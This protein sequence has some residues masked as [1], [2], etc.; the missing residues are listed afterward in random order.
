M[1]DDWKSGLM[2]QWTTQEDN[3]TEIEWTN[4]GGSTWNPLDV[5]FEHSG[6]A[7]QSG[8]DP[9]SGRSSWSDEYTWDAAGLTAGTYRLRLTPV[10]GRGNV[11]A[12]LE[13]LAFVVVPGPALP[14][15]YNTDGVVDAADYTVW[16]DNLG[17]AVAPYASADGSGNGE[18]G[19]EDYGVWRSN[20]GRTLPQ[21]V[22]APASLPSANLDTALAALDSESPA[23]SVEQVVAVSSD[24]PEGG[25]SVLDYAYALLTSPSKGDADDSVLPTEPQYV[26]SGQ[27]D[28]LL[29]AGERSSVSNEAQPEVIDTSFDQWDD[30]EEPLGS[31]EVRLTGV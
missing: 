30:S 26:P 28:L 1:T 19:P 25:L 13:T 17:T 9:A 29:L 20:Y 16:R 5:A 18:V 2:D 23:R 27:D 6:A 7:S 12:S 4:D 21:T 14:G 31:L 24:Q 10:D 3:R 8:Y 15:D 22:V 11:G